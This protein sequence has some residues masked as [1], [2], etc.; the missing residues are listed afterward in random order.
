M[1]TPQIK[2]MYSNESDYNKVQSRLGE[3]D[4]N[5]VKGLGLKAQY[6][7]GCRRSELCGKWAILNDAI[8]FDRFEGH[9][10]VV[11]YLKTAKRD[12]KIRPIALPKNMPWVPEISDLFKDRKGKAFPFSPK[13]LY[14]A[15]IEC[16]AGFEYEIDKYFDFETK[17]YV[18]NHKRC[19]ATHFSRHIRAKELVTRYKFSPIQLT[20][21]MGW[22][23][24]P[25]LGGSVMMDKYINLQWHDYVSKFL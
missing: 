5:C 12:G 18:D 9:D 17:K 8:S 14:R 11:F 2:T 16:Y 15:A 23:L 21:Y 7:F 10:V 13:T 4:E 3:L 1:S 22:K 6:L 25:N 19:A 24:G 20:Y